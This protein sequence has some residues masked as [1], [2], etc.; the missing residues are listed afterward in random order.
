MPYTLH[1]FYKFLYINAVNA[2]K[3]A[4]YFTY[5]DYSLS[6]TEMDDMSKSGSGLS[7]RESLEG[8]Y[9]LLGKGLFVFVVLWWLIKKIW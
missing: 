4:Q 5:G 7:I 1:N 6:E 2:E 8:V 3:K 9:M